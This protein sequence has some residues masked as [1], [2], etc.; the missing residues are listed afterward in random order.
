[1]YQGK[2][3]QSSNALRKSIFHPLTDIEKEHKL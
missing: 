1:M 2:E 3:I